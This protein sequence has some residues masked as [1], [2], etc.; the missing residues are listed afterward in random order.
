[1][2]LILCSQDLARLNSGTKLGPKFTGL[3]EEVGRAFSPN[4]RA[5]DTAVNPHDKKSARSAKSEIGLQF[6]PE[7]M[8]GPIFLD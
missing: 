7:P 6:F 4:E 3:I 5:W 1:M 8:N 2:L